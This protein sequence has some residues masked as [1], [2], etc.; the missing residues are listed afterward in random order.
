M[1]TSV[2]SE[3]SAAVEPSEAHGGALPLPAG[4]PTSLAGALERA[5]REFPSHGVICLDG[6]GGMKELLYP[7]L[8]D[9]ASRMLGGLR[10]LGLKPGAPVLFQLEKNPDF[11]PAF[12]AC[13]LGGFVPVPI[14]ISPTYEQP[15]SILS[16]LRNAWTMLD[17]PLTLAG[18]DLAP[19]LRAFAEREAL[20]GFR[21]ETADSLRAHPPAGAWHASQPDDLALLLL[22]SGSTGL[23]KAVRQT[24]R[25]LLAW[26]ASV[27]S[28]CEFTP[29]DISLNWMPLDHVGGLVMFHMRDVVIGCRQLLSP[30]EPI[31]QNPL[32]W[33]E[34]IE[35]YRATITWAPNFAFGLVNEQAA[36]LAQR[37]FDLSS[38]RFILNAGE[39]IVSKT[40]RRF[41][42]LL[43]PHGLPATAMRPAWGMSETS[44]AVTFSQRFTLA[45]TSDN[46]AFVEV[47]VPIPGIQ[48]RIVDQHDTPVPSGKIGRL[49]IKGMSVTPGYHQNPEA[50]E[51]SYTADGWFITGDLGVMKDGQ[52]S[53]T[54]REKDVIIING[55]NFYSHE[56]ESVVEEIDGV[57]V[58]FT[59]ACAIRLPAENTDRVAVFF[60]PTTAAEG[61]LP[62]LVR[63]IRSTV[64]RKE[65]VAPDFI[66]PLTKDDIPKTAIGKIQRAQ[67][68]KQFESGDFQA[69]LARG[70]AE[71]APGS[72][73]FGKTWRD[74][75]LADSPSLPAG[76]RVLIFADTTG[77]G[78]G[79]AGRLRTAGHACVVVEAGEEF[80]AQGRETFRLNPARPADYPRLWQ[81][82][83]SA[84]RF[85]HAVHAWAYPPAA[86]PAGVEEIIATQNPGSLSLLRLLRTWPAP[87]EGAPP[88]RLL[89]VTSRLQ[90]V[91]AE[92]PVDYAKAPV[93][94]LTRTLPHEFTW[95]GCAQLDLEAADPAADLA[96]VERELAAPSTGEWALRAGR[97]LTPG[98]IGIHLSNTNEPR[99]F[100][101]GGLYLLSGGFGGIGQAVAQRLAA[102][103]QAR[104]LIL[105]RTPLPA[106]EQWDQALARND[107][108]AARLRAWQA[109][110]QAGAEVHYEAGDL[111][112][113]DFVQAAVGRATRRWNQP[114]SGIIHLAG[115][116][117]E[118]VLAEES[119]DGWLQSLRP[120]LLGAWS[121]DRAA[122]A[123]P[124][125]L[126]VS[127]SSVL[128]H[129]SALG[130][131]A[132]AAANASL[133]AFAHYQKAGGGHSHSVLWSLW[134][135]TG[136]G[137]GGS[138]EAMAARGCL[139]LT[140]D[141][142]V[143][144]LEASLRAEPA[145]VFAGLDA[146]SRV[147]RRHL[148][149]S[150]AP[151][152]T[153]AAGGYVAPRS[154]LEQKL[155][156]MWQEILAVPKVGV[157]DNFFDLGGR[158][159]LAAR[160]FAR[161]DKEL[162][163][164]LPLATLF[165]ASTVET[166][167]ALLGSTEAPPSCRV[168]AI[169]SS[170]TRPPFFCIPGAGSD[171]IVFQSLAR[172]L[173]PDQPFYG[174]QARGLDATPIE[175]EF[176]S[177]EE[178][179]AD[180][181]KAMQSVQPRGPYFVGGHCFGSLIAWEVARQLKAGGNEVALIALLDPIVSNVFSSE[182]IGR[183]RLRYHFGKFLR[184][185]LRDKCGYFWE[186]IRNFSRTLLVRQRLGQSYGQAESM[187][188]RYQLG[189]YPGEVVIFLAEDSF[190]KLTPERDPRRYY[191]K[192]AKQG[193]RYLD[194]GG[195]HHSMLHHPAVPGLAAKLDGCL[196]SARSGGKAS[197]APAVSS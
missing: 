132:Y 91:S 153:A 52:L 138:S 192:I 63:T 43:A 89:V 14:S 137:R 81:A 119:D 114:L 21:I 108:T 121:L 26:V 79:L 33:L 197:S 59:A 170:G 164:K 122:R 35:R 110:E 139:A 32:L 187:H 87:A 47:G 185:S 191:E 130:T 102:R 106:R 155:A 168:L 115:E 40:T 136:M 42:S 120:K 195:D 88:V 103:Y 117:H 118:A 113:P 158:S 169:Q 178:V 38:M 151:A 145:Q 68:K 66:V 94:G 78:T 86:E 45:M 46:A 7:A 124:G 95:L 62:E 1:T 141:Q 23:P 54:G 70:K 125:C 184:M 150:E 127:F 25:N 36:E 61:R 73:L 74:A 77:L 30:T 196:Q 13:M 186:K 76:S 165:K 107:A 37:R 82:L 173:G 172:E 112:D 44:S 160:L 58:S 48:I 18:A 34:W 162:G 39:A 41:L 11:V 148:D 60:C 156:G 2:A 176:P 166:L 6:A 182:I 167:A 72:G 149:P 9:E 28:F 67:L 131:G 116:Y 90:A 142:G 163:H 180:F 80:A 84:G 75:P 140:P 96:A 194:V 133:D 8:L 20:A 19:R 51:K 85:T 53:I 5:A 93:L 29:A 105:G 179:A 16:K 147:L 143:D 146:S 175:G 97:R 126:F 193:A 55:V 69:A 161:I 189:S 111:A 101:A 4:H 109:L 128:G 71:S 190:F 49:Q 157:T 104:L 135:D 17:S 27:A 177:V 57:E 171:V 12:W 123:H 22:T 3:T 98:L 56:I 64:S 152:E 174:L 134:A 154:E 10:A 159:L 31:L 129:F 181:I 183:D 83:G 65:G 24:Q 144:L 100:S 92:E 99:G 188:R 50:N 15:H